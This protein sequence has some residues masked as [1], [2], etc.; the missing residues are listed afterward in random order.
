MTIWRRV[1]CWVG[2]ATRA[3]THASVRAPTHAR[4]YALIHARVHTHTHRQKSVT[5]IAFLRQQWF[6]ER[7]SKLPLL[8]ICIVFVL[9]L[10]SCAGF[11]IGCC[12][13]EPAR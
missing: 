2:E 9:Y 4:A 10:C 6:H 3:Q 12:P 11:I 7:A 8:Y 5:L 13:V 1:A